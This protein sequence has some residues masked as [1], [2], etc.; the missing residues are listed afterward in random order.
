MTIEIRDYE[1]FDA[2]PTAGEHPAGYWRGEIDG[3]RVAYCEYGANHG[4]GSVALADDGDSATILVAARP[5]GVFLRVPRDD[6]FAQIA[7]MRRAADV[8]EPQVILGADEQIGPW[9]WSPMRAQRHRGIRTVEKWA[10]E[11]TE[12]N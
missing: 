7:L 1:F 11:N 10:R 5:W 2:L 3:R 4:R 8:C 6:A 12:R 9:T